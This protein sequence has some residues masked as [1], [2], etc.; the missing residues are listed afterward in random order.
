MK[1]IRSFLF[2]MILAAVSLTLCSCGSGFGVP[3]YGKLESMTVQEYAN[4]EPISRELTCDIENGKEYRQNDSA[5]YEWGDMF[6]KYHNFRKTNDKGFA[7]STQALLYRLKTTDGE[8][9]SFFVYMNPEGT[10]S[11]FER[12]DGVVWKDTGEF[13][14]D[15]FTGGYSNYQ[16]LSFNDAYEEGAK[17]GEYQLLPGYNGRGKAILV[18]DDTAIAEDPN[19]TDRNIRIE[20]DR[21]YWEGWDGTGSLELPVYDDTF[22]GKDH[23]YL[24]N[25]AEDVRFIV[26]INATDQELNGYWVDSQGNHLSNS[27]TTN[28]TYELYDLVTGER[29]LF[30]DGPAAPEEIK[31][32]IDGVNKKTEQ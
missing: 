30:E 10:A 13:G 5:M 20:V 16:H 11:Y 17:K 23:E 19:D 21:I 2:C 8:E 25:R 3:K 6:S 14:D 1:R 31:K 4:G 9:I 18:T 7:Q 15:P 26:R 22:F 24:A 28:H 29:V 32:Y 12:P 27:Y